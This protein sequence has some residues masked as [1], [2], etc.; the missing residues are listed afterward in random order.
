MSNNLEKNGLPIAILGAGGH[1]QVIADALRSSP[2]TTKTPLIFL[3]D[4]PHIHGTERLGIP[5][6]GAISGLSTFPH[7]GV[8]I[9]IGNNRIRRKIAQRLDS[10]G[11]TFVTVI[12][13]RATIARDVVLGAG[14]VVFAHA[15]VNT[16]S[17][18]GAHVILNTGSTVDHHNH[19]ANYVHVAPGAHTGGDVTLGEGAFIGIGAIV[20][21][22]RTVGSWAT[23]GAGAVVH[24]NVSINSTVVGVPA[25]PLDAI[26]TKHRE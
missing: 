16:G 23:V 17:E 10:E 26:T 1:A 14:T 22:Q 21:P 20:M 24:Q 15:V 3:D 2:S 4:D 11:E 13:P 8:V 18:I 19:L 6:V 5:I 9:A 25:R 12:H 7:R